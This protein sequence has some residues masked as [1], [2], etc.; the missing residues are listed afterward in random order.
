MSNA[1]EYNPKKWKEEKEPLN[2]LL[3][4]F[5]C[6][7]CSWSG[8]SSEFLSHYFGYFSQTTCIHQQFSMH[9]ML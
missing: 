1:T 2:L 5:W 8:I 7:T 9:T 3:K 6:Q 4:V